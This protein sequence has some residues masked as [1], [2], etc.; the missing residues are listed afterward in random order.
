VRDDDFECVARLAQ[1]FHRR[2][3][4]VAEVL[5]VLLGRPASVFDR[6]LSSSVSLMTS[7]NAFLP[8]TD[9][10]PAAFTAATLSATLRWYSNA[11]GRM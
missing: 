10:P 9:L 4:D 2:D 3:D 5:G 11:A 1:L 6:R 7:S 8:S